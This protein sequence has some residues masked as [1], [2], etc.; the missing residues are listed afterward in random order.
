MSLNVD[1][2]VPPGYKFIKCH[3]NFEVKMDF[4]RKAWF[5]AGGH[6]TDPP[7]FLTYSSIVSRDGVHIGFTLAALN[8][9]DLIS[10]DIGNAYLQAETK[11]KVYMIAG[12][13]FGK[14]QGFKTLIIWALC[15][16]NQVELH[17]T[18][19]LL[20]ICKIKGLH[21]VML[22]QM[23][24]FTLLL[25]HVVINIMNFYWYMWMTF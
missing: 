12:P 2:H 25:S 15:G 10:I 21:L 13:E 16:L 8:N 23:Y 22:I 1:E 5:L 24:G 14:M 20:T 11:A 19:T 3:M 6:M 18:I 4:M 9:L 7:P 17:G